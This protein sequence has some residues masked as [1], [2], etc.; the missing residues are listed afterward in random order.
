MKTVKLIWRGLLLVLALIFGALYVLYEL[1][2]D[3]TSTGKKP[4]KRR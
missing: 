2:N 4:T 3:L 1:F